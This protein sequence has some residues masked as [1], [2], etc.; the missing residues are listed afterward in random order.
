ML[1]RFNRKVQL[2]GVMREARQRTRFEKP[3]TRRKRKEAA[4]RRAAIRSARKADIRK[5]RPGR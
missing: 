5:G 3:P 4:L 2:D 1:K